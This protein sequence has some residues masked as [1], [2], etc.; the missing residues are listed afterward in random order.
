MEMKRDRQKERGVAILFALGILGMMTVLALTFA[1]ISMTNQT[2]AHNSMEQ[3]SAK[4]LSESIAQRIRFMLAKITS[5]AQLVRFYSNG[6]A[7]SADGLWKLGYMGNIMESALYYDGG[8]TLDPLDFTDAKAYETRPTWQYIKNDGKIVARFAYFALAAYQPVVDLNSLIFKDKDDGSKVTI[9]GTRQGVALYELDPDVLM[10]ATKRVYTQA[11]NPSFTDSDSIFG[12]SNLSKRISFYSELNKC[13]A[14]SEQYLLFTRTF[15]PNSVKY[16]EIFLIDNATTCYRFDLSQIEKNADLTARR[17]WVKKMTETGDLKSLGSDGK[18]TKIPWLDGYSDSSGGYSSPAQKA[19][20][21]A[22]NIVDFVTEGSEPTWDSAHPDKSWFEVTPSYIG[23]KKTPYLFGF[24]GQLEFTVSQSYR[25]DEK[26][27]T[28]YTHSLTVNPSF[29]SFAEFCNLYTLDTA[30]GVNLKLGCRGTITIRYSVDNEEEASWKNVNLYIDTAAEQGNTG[31]SPDSPFNLKNPFFEKRSYQK[32]SGAGDTINFPTPTENQYET[33]NVEIKRVDIDLKLGI[34]YGGFWVD[35]SEINQ[36]SNTSSFQW[37]I[38]K[39]S[40]KTEYDYNDGAERKM[41]VSSDPQTK[42]MGL[43]FRVSDP[44]HN[45]FSSCWNG[46][47]SFDKQDYNDLALN[48]PT[49]IPD[50]NRDLNSNPL[51]AYPGHAYAYLPQAPIKAPWE[52]GQIHRG[53]AWQTINLK[54]YNSTSPIN[55]GSY[56]AGDAN[57]LDQIR[58]SSEC[59]TYGK[60]PLNEIRGVYANALFSALQNNARTNDNNPNPDSG[61]ETFNVK[62]EVTAASFFD[63]R[64]NNSEPFFRYRSELADLLSYSNNT[65][66]SMFDT[67]DSGKP[68]TDAAHEELFSKCVM[69]F[70]AEPTFLPRR[71]YVFGIVQTIKDMEGKIYRK[72]DTGFN[73]NVKSNLDLYTAGYVSD[74]TGNPLRKIT[75][76][77]GKVEIEIDNPINA[78]K[79]EFDVGAD[80]ILAE[81]KFVMVLERNFVATPN[82]KITW[83]IVRFEYVQ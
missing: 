47:I 51:T 36:I 7:N 26:D 42:N 58:F 45:L 18:T 41:T 37:L 13:S 60:I 33:Y 78:K 29:T 66:Y 74:M 69:L 48:L 14:S 20:Q 70:H 57:L 39:D 75:T 72:W 68:T 15:K 79:G 80:R 28:K 2:I 19:K 22:A 27:P 32:R 30:P 25:P 83:N 17:E 64:K 59:E 5:P 63:D 49:S 8:W 71:I 52:I 10:T 43:I 35:F 46:R 67:S 73:F 6:G 34:H 24:G 12:L 62:Q 9:R 54:K 61:K 31:E 23:L 3:Y 38:K 50:Q 81:Q 44:R 77:N 55:G 53:D 40:D 65:K 56:L 21:I 76:V 4:V 1:S 82:D 11:P 16:P